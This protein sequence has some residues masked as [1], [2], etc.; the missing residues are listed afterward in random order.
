MNV[1]RLIRDETADVLFEARASYLMDLLAEAQDELV[2]ALGNCDV[3]AGKAAA[4]KLAS[5]GWLFREAADKHETFDQH[6]TGPGASLLE[7][8]GTGARKDTP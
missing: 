1:V 2:A 3:E 4:R 7:D 5:V 8:R 6:Q